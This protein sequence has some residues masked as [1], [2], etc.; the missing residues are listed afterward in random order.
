MTPALL[1]RLVTIAATIALARRATACRWVALTG[2]AVASAMTMAVA[3]QVI[4]SG[5]PVDGVLIR[6]AA[7]GITLGYSVTALSA[8]FLMVLGLIAIPVACYSAEYFSHAIAPSR[9]AV[10]GATFNALLGAVEVVFTAGDVTTFL[11]AWELMTLATAALVAT[12]HETRENRQAAFLYLV[13]SHVGTGCLVAG[14]FI[15]SSA[16]GSLS[17]ATL[18]SGQIAPGPLRSALFILFFAGFGVKAGVMPLHVWLPDAHPAAP[19]SVSA[20]MSAVLITAGVYGLF[21]VCAFG[22]GTPDVHWGLALMATGV[23]SAILGILYALAQTDI[24]RLLAYSTIENAGIIVLGLGA[25]MVA[26]SSGHA[27]LAAIAMAASL[28]HVLNHAVF[29]GLLFLGAGSVVMATGTRKIE[30]FG[31]LL[32]VMPWTGLCFVIGAMAI[33]GLPLLNGFPSEWLTFQALLLGFGSTTGWVRLNFPLGF[34]M[35]ALTTALSAAC[36]VR[37]FGMSF[38]ARPRGAA[39]AAAHESGALMLVPQSA[40]AILCVGLGLFPG[41]ALHALG[42]VLQS[43]PGLPPT[44]ELARG[45]LAMASG[46]GSNDFV[47]PALLGVALVVALGAAGLVTARVAARRAPTW[48]CGGELTAQTE[49]T[50]TAFSKP[51]L[52]IFRAV[53]RPTREVEALAG[54]SPYFPRE[55]R[56]R[57]HIEPTFERYVYG[58]MARAVMQVADGMKVLQAGSLH[59]YLAYVLVFAM[60]LLIWLGGAA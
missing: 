16:S 34:A 36:F 30:E 58:P 7:S 39:A 42:G 49:Y 11:F 10:V 18:L 6:H 43:L 38:L 55:V 48:G 52:M 59:A 20:L 2:S 31:G 21:R 19:S 51:L 17:L 9:I 29:K 28:T 57:A 24:K 40:L 53:Y 50:A 37:A 41:V 32:R 13:M 5:H 15:L 25:G 47:A 46:I 22:L 3:I 44:V 26:L 14:F 8:W 23:L 27:E 60:L 33:A 1:L 35:L 45:G 54:V 56:Y 12:E 4:A